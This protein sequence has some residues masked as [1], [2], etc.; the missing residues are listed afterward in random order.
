L[1]A[2]APVKLRPGLPRAG[3]LFARG[4]GDGDAH[5]QS[6]ARQTPEERKSRSASAITDCDRSSRRARRRQG[7]P[8][9]Q[10]SDNSS[11][12]VTRQVSATGRA[13]DPGSITPAQPVRSAPSS[14][15]SAAS[16]SVA[17]ATLR[18]SRIFFAGEKVS[19]FDAAI[20]MVSPVAGLRPWRAAR[21]LTLKRPKPAR[22]TSSP[23]LAAAVMAETRCRGSSW[24]VPWPP[25]ARRRRARPIRWCSCDLPFRNDGSSRLRSKALASFA[26]G[27]TSTGDRVTPSTQSYGSAG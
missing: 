8:S 21:S 9:G 14:L 3:A 26:L 11:S 6:N 27:Q 18:A 17:A 15:Q 24:R 12:S 10:L 5:R 19:F 22:T 23:A 16:R 1:A 4:V 20:A 7:R 2:E 25:R 13:I